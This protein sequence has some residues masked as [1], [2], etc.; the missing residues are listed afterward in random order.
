MFIS[1][2]VWPFKRVG[3][4]AEVSHELPLA[5]GERGHEVM[6]VTPKG[7]MSAEIEAQ[8]NPTDISFEVPVSWR[9]HRAGVLSMPLSPQV[10]VYLISHEHL[11]DREGLY[12]NAFGDYEDNAERFIFFSRAAL[13]LAMA[14]GRPLDI[15]HAN[16]WTAGLVPLYLKSLYAQG[17]VF[18]GAGSL[19]TVHNLGNQGVFWHY[20]MPLTGLDWEYF[21]PEAI[22]FYGKINF[23][24]AGLVFADMIS[25]V[26]DRYAREVLK[27]E[28]GQG[29]EGVLKARTDRLA[30]ITNGI[31]YAKWDPRNDPLL[32]ASF[33]SE[34]LT[35]KKD[36][37]KELR[38]IFGLSEETER[39]LLVFIGRLLNRR[40]M[41]LIAPALDD[42]LDLGVDMAFMG[43][44]EDHYHAFLND[45]NQRRPQN[46]GVYIGYDEDLD[47]KMMGGADI[48]LMPSKYEP[49][50]LHQMHALRY[51][52]V[53]VVRATG[54]L[55]DTVSNHT[56]SKPGVGFKFK[57]YSSDA[58]LQT[59]ER[60]LAAYQNQQLWTQI[61][62]R[63]MDLDF[64]WNRVVLQYEQLYQRTQQL[65][66]KGS[67]S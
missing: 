50:G 24:K 41:D 35:P 64:S 31:D 15:V 61:M 59:I 27:P 10:T 47:H 30:A 14:L 5:L 2:E 56:D 45:L 52:T 9:N 53:P 67:E 8:L 26:S 34:N 38:R 21:T 46:L 6:V 13:E 12:G 48:L 1:P 65:R 33:S 20:D 23:L 29:L 17:E 43:F 55:D 44:G 25:T 60:A 36:C 4:L 37:Q 28:A 51:G 32:A 7:R 62:R 40:G 11:F 63:G 66:Q 22:E 42:I 58:L 39:P 16:D 3:G 18:A 57:P 19:M 49:C 54:G